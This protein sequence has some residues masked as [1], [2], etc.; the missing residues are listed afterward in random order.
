MMNPLVSVIIPVYNVEKYIRECLASVLR[1]SYDKMEIILVDDGGTDNSIEVIRD[2]RNHYLGDKIIKL[3]S[4]SKNRGQSEARNTGIKHSEGDFVFFLDSDDLLLDQY[5]F[6]IMINAQKENC[7]DIVIGNTR[8]FDDETG[9]IYKTVDKELSST[10]YSDWDDT[11]NV[12]PFPYVAWN[13]LIKRSFLLDHNLSFDKGIVYEDNLWA[14]KVLCWSAKISTIREYTYGY[15]YRSNSTMTTLK[16]IHI[17][18]SVLL[19]ILAQKYVVENSILKRV[20]ANNYIQD[21]KTG[22]LIK[23][24]NHV[25]GNSFYEM[26]YDIYRH[27]LHFDTRSLT[28]KRLIRESHQFLPI[29]FGRKVEKLMLKRKLRESLGKLEDDT[30]LKSLL[31][32]EL[33]ERNVL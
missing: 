17:V 25:E 15:R 32:K 27:F 1:Q 21:L 5:A 14:F 3:I 16:P 11:H 8:M 19:P 12:P 10:H 4:H 30:E 2:I 33:G 29:V 9:K 23:I 13:K 7:A 6:E 18:S 26:V 22:A 28:L 24:L 20:Y 31:L